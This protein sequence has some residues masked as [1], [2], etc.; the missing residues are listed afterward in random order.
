M[1]ASNTLVNRQPLKATG[2]MRSPRGVWGV[3]V[4]LALLPLAGLYQQLFAS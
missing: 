1:N 4:L 3:I 2:R